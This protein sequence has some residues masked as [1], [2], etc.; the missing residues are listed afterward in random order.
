MSLLKLYRP[1]PQDRNVKLRFDQAESATLSFTAH[2]QKTQRGRRMMNALNRARRLHENRTCPHCCHPVVEPLELDD[3]VVG[4][5]Q[6]PIPGTATLVGFHCHGC[7]QEW[8][9]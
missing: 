9:A 2:Y 3:A 6:M 5:S 7:D 1:A 4:K 8:S